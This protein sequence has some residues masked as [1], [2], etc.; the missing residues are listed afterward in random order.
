MAAVPDEYLEQCAFIGDE[1]RIR[2]R[3]ATWSP[4]ALIHRADRRRARQSRSSVWW[5][6]LRDGS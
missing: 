6:A 5:P 2:R 3:W 4:P 1:Q